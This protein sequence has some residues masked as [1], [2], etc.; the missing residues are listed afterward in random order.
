MLIKNRKFKLGMCYFADLDGSQD[1]G[2][3]GGSGNDQCQNQDQGNKD[4]GQNK[5]QDAKFTQEDLNK[6][7]QTRVNEMNIKHQKELDDLKAKMEREAE[8]SKMNENDRIKAELEDLRAKNQKYEDDIALNIQ[9]EQTRQFLKDA[10]LPDSFLK[11]V[12]VP[13]DE[14]Q[15]KV[16]ITDLKTVFEAE[17]KKGVEAQIKPHKPN[18]ISS[19]TVGN[20]NNRNS[21]PSYSGFNLQNSVAEYYANQK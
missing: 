8:L 14:N 1:G 21:G 4:Q 13:K 16:N 15:T 9:S 5:N 17:I 18:G 11:F 7:L 12:L 10:N 19:A 6:L 20:D 3:A 2:G